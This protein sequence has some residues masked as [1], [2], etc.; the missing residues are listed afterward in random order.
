MFPQQLLGPQGETSSKIAMPQA[1]LILLMT[2]LAAF[3]LIA[4]P[5]FSLSLFI[6]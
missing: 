5:L 3:S 2:S 4:L 1:L 6:F